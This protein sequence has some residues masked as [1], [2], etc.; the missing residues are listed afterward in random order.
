MASK[1]RID[2]RESIGPLHREQYAQ[3]LYINGALAVGGAEIPEIDRGAYPA[4]DEIRQAM[5][6]QSGFF[7]SV[8][9]GALEN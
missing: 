7:R 6:G 2:E 4:D 3:K 9:R 1:Q 5:S 8:F